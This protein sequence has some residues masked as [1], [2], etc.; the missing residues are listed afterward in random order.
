MGR[1]QAGRSVNP[2]PDVMMVTS[3]G[4]PGLNQLGTDLGDLWLYVD[5]NPE[6]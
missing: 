5:I 1:L 3:P 6:T 4:D 2:G